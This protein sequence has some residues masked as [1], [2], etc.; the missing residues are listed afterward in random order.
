MDGIPMNKPSNPNF[1][2]PKLIIILFLLPFFTIAQSKHTGL[3]VGVN[4][5]NWNGNTTQFGN[6]LANEMNQQ[7]GFSSFKFSPKARVGLSMSGFIEFPVQKSLSIQPELAYNQ[8][9][10][11]FSG[12]GKITSS[13]ESY[14][15]DMDMT[16]QWD[17]L[18]F[19]L[20]AKYYLTEENKKPYLLFGPG[21]GYV[22]SSGINVSATVDGESDSQSEQIEGVKKF[23]ANLNIGAGI[24]FSESIRLELRYS[25]GMLSLL[26]ESSAVEGTF[27][28]S[29][30]SLSLA[31]CF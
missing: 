21:L 9:G 5:G 1:M 2:K 14:H 4:F 19:A 22:V 7:S 13:G 8:R 10:I 17:Y 15:A 27:R 12:D 11:T 6:T 28:N 3:S 29:G 31:A 30:I 18:D 20:I 16:Y 26:D 25:K 23:D 24:D